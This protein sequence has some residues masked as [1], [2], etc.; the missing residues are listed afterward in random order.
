MSKAVWVGVGTVLVVMALFVLFRDE[1]PVAEIVGGGAASREMP[2]TEADRQ[3][4]NEALGA[5]FAT[6][7]SCPRGWQDALRVSGQAVCGRY[8]SN[9]TATGD[10]YYVERSVARLGDVWQAPWRQEGIFRVTR[11]LRHRRGN[12]LIALERSS[13]RVY[14]VRL[15]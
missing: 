12:Y 3:V 13:S 15:Q 4:V 11:T 1:L 2:S 14:V 7:V 5:L 10:R 8:E 9:R 6:Q